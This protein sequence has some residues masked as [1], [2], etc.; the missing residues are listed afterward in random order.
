MARVVVLTEADL[1]TQDL[2]GITDRVICTRA[3]ISQD[4]WIRFLRDF[5]QGPGVDTVVRIRVEPWI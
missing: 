4:L 1:K 5:A 2:L 3:G